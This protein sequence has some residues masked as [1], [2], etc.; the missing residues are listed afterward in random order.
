MASQAS[1]AWATIKADTYNGKIY[2]VDASVL[3]ETADEGTAEHCA[4]PVFLRHTAA[5][6]REW[7]ASAVRGVWL[8]IRGGSEDHRL[9]IA[10]WAVRA[11]L[12]VHRTSPT[13]VVC[14][15]WLP[16]DEP[17][18]LPRGSTHIVGE[19]TCRLPPAIHCKTAK[20]PVCSCVRPGG[21]R[22]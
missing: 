22:R 5:L 1:P 9:H 4:G 11:G 16:K 8:H 19:C 20:C 7:R 3:F 2:T 6:L 17:N 10:S 18:V 12:S 14:S 21:V 13:E 15:A